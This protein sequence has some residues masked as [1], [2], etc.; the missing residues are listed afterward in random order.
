M[1]KTTL[2]CILDG[3]GFNPN[4]KANAVALAKKPTIDKLLSTAAHTTLVTHGERVGLPDGQ[5]GNS[6]VGHLNIG[7]G[8][9]VEQWLLKISK[10]LKSGVLATS[11]PY[12]TFIE[13][14]KDAPALHLV[15][16]Y[17][18]GGVHSHSEHAEL[19]IRTV[20]KS[21]SG[22]IY[23]HVITDG[24]DTSPF[25]AGE[26]LPALLSVIKELPNVSLATLSGR[27]FA[28]DR[29]KR[30][31]RVEKAYNAIARGVGSLESDP[32]IAIKNSYAAK[33]TDEFIEPTVCKAAP[34]NAKDG[35][36]FWNFRED[37][38]R[39]IVAALATPSFDGFERAAPVIEKSR[40]LCCTEYDHTF[41]LPYLFEQIFIKN[42]LGEVVAEA[43]KKQLRVA[44]TEKY[45]HVT[46]FFN[47]GI[48]TP[49]AGEDR[50][51]VP[52][53]RDVKTYD[54][55]PEMSA[56]AVRDT[57]LEGLKSGLYDFIAVNFAN[58][59]MVGHT[60][61]VE[62]AVKAVETVDSCLGALLSELDAQ[63]GQAL[64]I[65]DHGNAEQLINY[66]DGTPHTA[67]TLFPVPCIAYGKG[68]PA[69]LQDGGALCDVTPT[70]L[71]MMGIA[72]PAEMT[73]KALF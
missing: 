29:D 45:P 20:A 12:R 40:V 14:T 50:K 35:L 3:F 47:G 16:L 39:E 68:A 22:P 71:K 54:L 30:W 2:L 17:S 60:G 32:M 9:V 46:Y 72:Q 33:I 19:L 41:H 56:A 37:R 73:G 11:E 70:L 57:V 65:A 25:R 31:D 49:Y 38:M 1:K 55:K 27:Y 58:C 13:A 8:R 18:D 61:V 62:A 51:V 10:A 64:I 21:F 59:D 53:P 43:G 5:M 44:E 34:F 36:I 69:K 48:E 6:E 4:T 63:G 26:Q 15:G 42:H 7:A 66:E 24:R 52:S 23:V 28:M 67:H